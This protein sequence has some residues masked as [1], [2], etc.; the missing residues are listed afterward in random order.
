MSMTE[1]VAVS[2][3]IHI[4]SL[5]SEIWLATDVY[6]NLFKVLMTFKIKSLGLLQQPQTEARS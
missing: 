5:A 4:A 6:V 3:L 1:A 2:N